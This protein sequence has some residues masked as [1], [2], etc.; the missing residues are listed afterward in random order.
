MA[1]AS[2]DYAVAHCIGASVTPLTR[3]LFQVEDLKM[4]TN[5]LL[6]VE[7]DPV[8]GELIRTYLTSE[9]YEVLHARSGLEALE[10][11]QEARRT[12]RVAL[13]DLYL[14]GPVSGQAVAEKVQADKPA[15]RIVLMSGELEPPQELAALP[16]LPKP[17]RLPDLSRVLREALG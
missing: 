14:E 8:L 16:F 11:W 1:D 17:F 15:T 4:P 10:L 6:L 12:V 5:T 9:G 7:D 3:L 2:S 13:V